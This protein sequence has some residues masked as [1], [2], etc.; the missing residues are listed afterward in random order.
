MS[1]HDMFVQ[2]TLCLPADVHIIWQV[3]LMPSGDPGVLQAGLLG[4]EAQSRASQELAAAPGSELEQHMPRADSWTESQM[5]RLWE[6]YVK[7][8]GYADSL[9]DISCAALSA[10]LM[11]S[12]SSAGHGDAVES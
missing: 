8:P 7:T 1:C 9:L 6:Q 12:N 5:D 3:L 11:C 4:S 10:E 2:A